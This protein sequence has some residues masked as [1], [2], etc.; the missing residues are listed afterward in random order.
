[1]WDSL[2][3][4]S[5]L[6]LS[7]SLSYSLQEPILLN[8]LGKTKMTLIIGSP[9]CFWSLQWLLYVVHLKLSI[10][11]LCQA[12]PSIFIGHCHGPSNLM[13]FDHLTQISI[14]WSLNAYGRWDRPIRNLQRLDINSVLVNGSQRNSQECNMLT[15]SLKSAR[16]RAS[17]RSGSL[18]K[19]P[20]TLTATYL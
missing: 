4:L 20:W 17:P 14:S 15:I 8:F 18:G 16:G 13:L 1:M 6:E 12:N 19:W 10:D 7:R 11:H 5:V 3:T 9:F 2:S